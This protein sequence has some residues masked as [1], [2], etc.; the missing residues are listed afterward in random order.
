MLGWHNV[1]RNNRKK[2][3]R[4]VVDTKNFGNKKKKKSGLVVLVSLVL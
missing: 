4:N 2:R 3:I 1:E